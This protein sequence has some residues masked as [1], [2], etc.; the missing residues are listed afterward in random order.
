[1]YVTNARRQQQYDKGLADEAKVIGWLKAQGYQVVP[2]TAQENKEDDI[3]IWV[4]GHGI[5]IKS[6]H[7]GARY[8]NI[9]LELCS[10]LTTKSTCKVSQ[11]V[12]LNGLKDLGTIDHLI[13][14]GSWE[15]GWFSTGRAT[16]YLFYQG[17]QMRLYTKASIKAYVDS[18]G[19]LRLRPLTEETKSYLGG[20]YRHCNT[21]CGYLTWGDVPH[22]LIS[23]PNGL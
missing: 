9:G 23:L 21:I 2:S 1:M 20:Y 15:P 17:N 11:K 22:R 5:S 19:F 3:D 14:T 18:K 13:A 10:L 4:N 12:L 16:K 6:Q 7:K 8:R